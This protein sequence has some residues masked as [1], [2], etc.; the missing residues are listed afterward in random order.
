MRPWK[1]VQFCSRPR[2][3]K[4][5]AAGIHWVF[6]GLKFEPND[7]IGQKGAFCK[8]LINI[9]VFGLD[10]YAGF[11]CAGKGGASGKKSMEIIRWNYL[12]K[13]FKKIIC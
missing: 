12:G 6:R 4:I 1:N 8:G 13:M 7:G 5:L 10:A 9:C 3:A 11:C 2:K